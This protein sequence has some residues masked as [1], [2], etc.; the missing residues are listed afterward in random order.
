MKNLKVDKFYLSFAAILIVLAV[1]V[2][3]TL[4]TAFS[5]VSVASEIDESLLQTQTPRINKDKLNEA[6]EVLGTKEILP[7]DLRL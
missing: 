6:L 7:L 2:I 1:M 5:A 4:R 3:F